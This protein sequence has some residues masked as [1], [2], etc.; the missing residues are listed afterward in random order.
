MPSN[1]A[2]VGPNYVIGPD[3]ELQVNIWGQLNFVRRLVVDHARR[4]RASRCRTNRSGWFAIWPSGGSVESRDAESVQEF[5][6]ERD[7]GPAALDSDFR[8]GRRAPTRQLHGQFGHDAGERGVR[9]GWTIVARSMRHIRLQRGDKKICEFDLYDLLMHGDTSKDAQLQ[10]GD[11][12]LITPAGPRVAV[13]GS[14]ER[15]GHL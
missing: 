4:D 9:F 7:T 15:A 6:I 11:V 14:V 1:R 13:A 8:G 10:G 12:I 5:R 2:L 3:D